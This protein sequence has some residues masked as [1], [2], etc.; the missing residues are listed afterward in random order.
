MKIILS[1]LLI[2][3]TAAAFDTREEMI[4]GCRQEVM[5]M[6]QKNKF[7]IFAPIEGNDLAEELVDEPEKMIRR[8]QDM[9][10]K[11]LITGS[12]KS[13]PWS[14][15]Y[16]PMYRGG[17]GQ[18][19][20]DPDFNAHE[21]KE[22][23]DYIRTRPASALIR[24]GKLNQLSPSEKYD[25]LLGLSKFPLTA[26]QWADGQRY[27][28]RS[29]IVESWMGLCHGW[30]VASMMMPEPKKKVVVGGMTFFPSDI[31]GLATLLWSRGEFPTRFIGGRCNTQNPRTDRNGRPS[32][33]NCID[34][35]PGSWHLVVVN[36][37]GISRRPF[38]MDAAYDYEVWNHPVYSYDY[39]YFNPKT[40]TEGKFIE[41]SVKPGNWDKRKEFRSADTRTIVGVRMSVIYAVENEATTEE[42]Q[43]S[44]SSSVSFEYDLE[45]NQSGEIVGG[46]WHSDTHPDF[47][48]VPE[49]GTYPLTLGDQLPVNLENLS[50][51]IKKAALGSAHKGLPMSNLV[52]TLVKVSS[53]Q[54]R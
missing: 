46:E 50:P 38:I 49:P 17:L 20:N 27:F 8:P 3:T 14:D 33:Q 35:N 31:K 12:A 42:D 32:E 30:A 26:S 1:F 6:A 43:T 13:T 41:S 24:E 23:N 29:G 5:K 4:Q 10:A 18:R 51:E 21:W 11:G 40:K 54:G 45:L 28:S 7:L 22:A 44:E 37:L 39:V 2:S 47:L 9:E 19:Y 52:K 16:W 34:N 36:Q 48:W 25:H 53:K 15:S